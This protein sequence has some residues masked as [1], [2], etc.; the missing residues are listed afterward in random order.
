M[1]VVKVLGL[2]LV[3]EV[4]VWKYIVF[5]IFGVVLTIGMLIWVSSL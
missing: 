5:T 1:K 2:S 3:F 4:G